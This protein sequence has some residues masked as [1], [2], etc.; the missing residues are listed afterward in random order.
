MIINLIGWLLM[1]RSLDIRYLLPWYLLKH[2]HHLLYGCR[3]YI[4][5]NVILIFLLILFLVLIELFLFIPRRLLTLLLLLRSS[6]CRLH[7]LLDLLFLI[8]G[9]DSDL[10]VLLSGR[11]EA[12][13]CEALGCGFLIVLLLLL[14][15]L[16]EGEAA[17]AAPSMLVIVDWFTHLY[18]NIA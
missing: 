2:L 3:L 1:K 7:W 11:C 16:S 15:A 4:L 9:G 5:L 18:L 8:F 17:P 13:G 10:Q 12:L 6:A 14:F